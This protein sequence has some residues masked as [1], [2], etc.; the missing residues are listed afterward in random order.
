MRLNDVRCYPQTVLLEW[1]DFLRDLHPLSQFT[2]YHNTL[3]GFVLCLGCLSQ[4][5][6]SALDLL[7]AVMDRPIIMSPRKC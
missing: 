2:Q 5:E 6:K 4:L 7:W 3:A 1:S